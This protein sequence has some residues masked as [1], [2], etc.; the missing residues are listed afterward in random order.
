MHL[1]TNSWW[2]VTESA[3]WPDNPAPWLTEVFSAIARGPMAG[4]PLCNPALQVEAVAF[5]PVAG[6]W[7]GILVTPWGINLLRLPG[8]GAAWPAARVGDKVEWTFPSGQYEFMVVETAELGSYHLC[9]L[10]SP[11]QEFAD[12]QQARL[13]AEAAMA[14]LL[15][16]ENAHQAER[17][18][19]RAFLGLRG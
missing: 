9:S 17:P 1:A 15:A 18:S 4:L 13:T 7:T 8:L 11:A 3:G 19:R 12:Q 14:A 2:S 6:H 5:Q 16:G 10:F